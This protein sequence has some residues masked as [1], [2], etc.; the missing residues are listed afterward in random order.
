MNIKEQYHWSEQATPITVEDARILAAKYGQ[1]VVVIVAWNRKTNI[2]NF[3]T[4]GSEL[5]Y[6]NAAVALR[7][8]IKDLMGVSE[9]PGGTHEDRRH[10]HEDEGHEHEV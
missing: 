7:D 9:L 4:V 8:Q 2:H 6:A 10:E 1:D 3:V 5:L